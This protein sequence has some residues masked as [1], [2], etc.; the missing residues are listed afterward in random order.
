MTE[1]DA[2]SVTYFVKT[3]IVLSTLFLAACGVEEDARQQLPDADS[4][5]SLQGEVTGAA[6]ANCSVYI[7]GPGS[8]CYHWATLRANEEASCAAAGGYIGFWQT[9]RQC[10]ET[11]TLCDPGFVCYYRYGCCL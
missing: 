6:A 1:K 11:Q 9:S 3:A 4:E 2:V 10:D 8:T 5:S 7:I